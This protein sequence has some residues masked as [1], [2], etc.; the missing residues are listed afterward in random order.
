MK[1]ITMILAFLILISSLAYSQSNPFKSINDQMLPKKH[2]S[3]KLNFFKSDNNSQ[4]IS[5]STKNNYEPKMLKNYTQ[6]LDS[7]VSCMY[8]DESGKV[9][10][11][12][13]SYF[14]YDDK[15]NNIQTVYLEWSSENNEW[16]E[17]QR[18]SN[19]YDDK[20]KIIE[21]IEEFKYEEFSNWIIDLKYVYKYDNNDNL[22]DTRVFSYNSSSLDWEKNCGE[23][24]GYD[25][26]NNLLYDINWSYDSDLAKWY[27]TEKVENVYN[28]NNQIVLKTEYNDFDAD[29]V[30]HIEKQITS[31]YDDSGKLKTDVEYNWNYDTDSLE[32]Y[33]T[34]EY[35]YDDNGVLLYETEIYAIYDG[36]MARNSYEFDASG[37]PVKITKSYF[38]S[39]SSKYI[40]YGKMENEYDQNILFSDVCTPFEKELTYD[41]D[42]YKFSFKSKIFNFIRYNFNQETKQL[43][44]YFNDKFF[45]SEIVSSVI[46]DNAELSKIYPNPV[47]DK[48]FF[49]F[50]DNAEQIYFELFDLQGRIVKSKNISNNEILNVNDLC[51]GIYVYHLTQNGKIQTGK[52]IKE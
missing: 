37:N 45:Y 8:N 31:E 26:N 18:E 24:Y 5:K 22:I 40:L 52:L 12:M 51:K 21:K 9:E 42:T 48:L 3:S 4:K 7:V 41:D 19:K 46:D 13:K 1:K 44:L 50:A 47:S 17:N 2:S 32:N 14:I 49:S 28:D 11:S 43:E 25:Q 39:D 23:T 30:F 38:D 29:T 34:R 35:V 16:Y 15:N 33:R 27:I 6:K 10:N 20:N 36:A